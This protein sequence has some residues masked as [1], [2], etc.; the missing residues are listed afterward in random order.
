MVQIA[1]WNQKNE[2]YYKFVNM[3]AIMAFQDLLV[4]TFKFCFKMLW[5]PLST[6]Y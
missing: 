4:L 6:I 1:N 5:L 3:N 2:N